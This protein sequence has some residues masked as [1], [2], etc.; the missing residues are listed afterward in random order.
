MPTRYA[1]S[2]AL[3]VL[4]LG[5]AA[6]GGGGDGGASD[7]ALGEKVV[8]EHA[9]DPSGTPSTLGITVLAVRKGT[10]EEMKQGGFTLEGEELTRTPYYVDTRFENQGSAAIKRQLY[11]AMEDQDGNLIT[12]TTIIDLGGKPFAQCPKAG[13]AKLAPGQ[14]YKSCSLFLVPEGREPTKVSFLPTDPGTPTEFV[15]WS[16]E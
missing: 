9:Q 7:H 1:G 4:S 14:S 6:C 12:S 2:L 8:V 10:Q 16:V 3:V 13:D 11:V 5:L 15:Y